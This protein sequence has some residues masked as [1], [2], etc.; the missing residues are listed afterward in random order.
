[1]RKTFDKTIPLNFNTA[2]LENPD[3]FYYEAFRKLMMGLCITTPG[4]IVEYDRNSHRAR[5][6]P[7]IKTVYANGYEEVP[8]PIT[9]EVARMCA[10]G[11]VIDFPIK[12]GDTGWFISSDRDVTEIKMTG[13]IG[14]PSSAELHSFKRG[15]WIPDTWGEQEI[16]DDNCLV[17]QSVD[18][19]QKITVGNGNISI[20]APTVTV[21]GE[22]TIDGNTTITGNLVVDGTTTTSESIVLDSHVHTGNLGTST[23]GPLNP[24]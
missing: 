5:V 22:T 4:K 12:A 2:S 9:V 6:Q 21:K 8:Q 10:G 1:M 14:T 19:L 20:I 23:S 13:E 24:Q 3:V 15:F 16:T 11:F 17:I 18:G 7:M